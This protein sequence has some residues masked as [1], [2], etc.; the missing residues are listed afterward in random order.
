MILVTQIITGRIIVHIVTEDITSVRIRTGIIP[1]TDMLSYYT[2]ITVLF[3]HWV[4]DF[5]CQTDEQAQGKSK[6]NKWLLSHVQTYS[7]GLILIALFNMDLFVSPEL[8][9]IVTIFKMAAFVSLNFGLHFFTDYVTSRASSL[10]WKEGKVHDFFV[11]IGA[12]QMIH[13][14]TLFGTLFWITQ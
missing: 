12:D 10:L 14:I 7:I 6:E 13:Y 4:F 9:G 8:R 5:F 3:F 1:A 2:I 11:T